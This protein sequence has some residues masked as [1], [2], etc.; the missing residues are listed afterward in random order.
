MVDIELRKTLSFEKRIQIIAEGIW[1]GKV[2][3]NNDQPGTIAYECG[4]TAQTINRDKKTARFIDMYETFAVEFMKELADLLTIRD[5]KG[6]YPYLGLAVSEKGRLIR[7]MM[8]RR[9]EGAIIQHIVVQPV[10]SPSLQS[11]PPKQV[12]AEYEEEE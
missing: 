4:V 9:V 10:F 8:P 1:A 3:G 5:E 2:I 6:K 12:E 11:E 7:A